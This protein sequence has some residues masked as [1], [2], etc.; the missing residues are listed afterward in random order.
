MDSEWWTADEGNSSGPDSTTDGEA[1]N[2]D[3]LSWSD[4]NSVSHSDVIYEPEWVEEEPI[5]IEEDDDDEGYASTPPTVTL[6]SPAGTELI[7][8]IEEAYNTIDITRTVI[9][10]DPFTN[11][12][13]LVTALNDRYHT[14]AVVT[15]EDF[16]DP[17]GRPRYMSAVRDFNLGLAR[18]LVLSSTMWERIYIELPDVEILHNLLILVD[19]E[20]LENCSIMN[21]VNHD[22]LYKSNPTLDYYVMNECI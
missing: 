14:V 22:G 12:E 5:T 21:S 8:K 16:E 6:I 17:D 13:E 2:M 18:V 4:T 15:E 10:Y 19:I 9:I 7:D 3:Q 20:P 11:A 1:T